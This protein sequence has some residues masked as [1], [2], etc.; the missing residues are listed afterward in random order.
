[1]DRSTKKYHLQILWMRNRKFEY[2]SCWRVGEKLSGCKWN[3]PSAFLEDIDVLR[4]HPFQV[5]PVSLLPEAATTPHL[6]ELRSGDWWIHFKTLHKSLASKRSSWKPTKRHD[7]RN[8]GSNERFLWQRTG[9]SNKRVSSSLTL[10]RQG[11]WWHHA[12]PNIFETS[13]RRR[14]TNFPI[15]STKVSWTPDT[16]SQT[17]FQAGLSKKATKKK[18]LTS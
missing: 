18:P 5:L 14:K 10:T 12:K 4:G 9:T 1:M 2:W 17:Q 16:S 8:R 7:H 15:I 6:A 11:W 3:Y 13:S